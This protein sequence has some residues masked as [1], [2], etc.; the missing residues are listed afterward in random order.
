MGLRLFLKF[1]NYY[2]RFII[3]QLEEIKLFIRITKKDE[4]R[5]WDNK[6]IELFKKIKKK[7][8]EEPILKIY[9]LTLPMRVKMNILDFV[10]RAC[11]LQKQNK[12]Q[13]PVVYYNQKIALLKLNYDI[14][15][16]ELLGIV[17]AFKE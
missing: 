13:H 1:Y 17:T 8:I 4:P 10:L 16:K 7:F 14:Y 9:Q 5:K 2:K 3:K 15:N 6:K 12:V 11:L